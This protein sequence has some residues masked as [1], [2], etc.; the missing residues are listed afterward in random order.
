MAKEKEIITDFI[1]PETFNIY[2]SVFFGNK[3]HVFFETYDIASDWFDKVVSE[4]KVLVKLKYVDISLKERKDLSKLIYFKRSKNRTIK[5]KKTVKQLTNIT[6]KICYVINL[7]KEKENKLL[8]N[9]ICYQN[10]NHLYNLDSVMTNT[11]NESII[12]LS[13]FEKDNT[14]YRKVK[15]V[16]VYES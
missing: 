14:F 8:D 10:I 4:L 16:T 1:I 11:D 7:E 13:K 15:K 3:L 9:I 2:S 12:S 5:P 6:W